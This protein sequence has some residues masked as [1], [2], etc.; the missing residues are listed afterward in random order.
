MSN[1]TNH[2]SME[3]IT[4]IMIEAGLPWNVARKIAKFSTRLKCCE[5]GTSSFKVKYHR[6]QM[7]DWEHEKDWCDECYQ[8]IFGEDSDDK[9]DEAFDRGFA[10]Y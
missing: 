5:C 9:I 2:V 10:Y 1:M 8:I 4:E 6:T 7:Y 3:M